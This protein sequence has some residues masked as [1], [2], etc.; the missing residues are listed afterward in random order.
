[1]IY[2]LSKSDHT[3][4]CD[5]NYMIAT[6]VEFINYILT[7]AFVIYAV[8]K[9]GEGY[10]KAYEKYQNPDS[11]AKEVWR[12]LCTDIIVLLFIVFYIWTFVWDCIVLAWTGDE[13]AV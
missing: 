5:N 12:F 10:F 7:V 11:I 6:V 3:D 4:V 1:M 2:V 13:N 9:I 8:R